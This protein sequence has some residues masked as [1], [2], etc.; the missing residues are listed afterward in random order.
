MG[1]LGELADRTGLSA[2]VTAAWADTYCGPWVYAPGDVFAD[3][4]AA[5]AVGV[6]CI[7]RVGQLCGASRAP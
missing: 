1:L 4:A 7:D 3:L 2:Q 5:V 6:D